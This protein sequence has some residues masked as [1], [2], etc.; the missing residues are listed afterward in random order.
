MR[1]LLHADFFRLFRFGNLQFWMPVAIMIIYPSCFLIIK[2]ISIGIQTPYPDDKANFNLSICIEFLLLFLTNTY[3]SNE[4]K[5]GAIRNKIIVGAKRKNIYLSYLLTIFLAALIMTVMWFIFIVIGVPDLRPQEFNSGSPGSTGIGIFDFISYFLIA[6]MFLAATASIFT[7]TIL[8][9]ENS[10]TG[11]LVSII[12]FFV[13]MG[14]VMLIP[15]LL[16][17]NE[18]NSLHMEDGVIIECER[19]PYYVGGA[20]RYILQFI[21][22]FLPTGQGIQLFDINTSD[23]MH[24]AKMLLSS[25]FI[26]VSTTITGICL[27]KRRNMK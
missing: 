19:N 25:A 14:S 4:Y 12:V 5:D 22:D 21:P 7:F 15:H 9:S 17:I 23:Y 11:A 2:Q 13:M 24:T 10:S 18:Y 1:K 27:F 6:V 16:N 26:T 20:A 8:S 3:L